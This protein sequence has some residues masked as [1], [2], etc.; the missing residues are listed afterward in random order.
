MTASGRG[1][2]IVCMNE[3]GAAGREPAG[4]KICG[5]RRPEDACAAARWAL[6]V[7]EDV[8]RNLGIAVGAV[9]LLALGFFVGWYWALPEAPQGV[10]VL[11]GTVVGA[12]AGWSGA[13]YTARAQERVARDKVAVEARRSRLEAAQ[14]AVIGLFSVLDRYQR[15]WLE[16]H[17]NRLTAVRT[18]EESFDQAFA[19][20]DMLCPKRL[21]AAYSDYRAA[22]GKVVDKHLAMLGKGPRPPDARAA[23]VLSV[24]VP[25]RKVRLAL[26][27]KAE[28]YF[29]AAFNE[30]AEA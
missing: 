1:H 24:T 30:L 27:E 12:L 28:E 15:A 29:T 14:N 17:E 9:L 23:E 2:S 20:M 19:Q 26:A 22:V 8:V 7:R 21:R 10:L 13:Y 6:R 11:G 3:E 25:C 16:P 18:A 4:V 5:L